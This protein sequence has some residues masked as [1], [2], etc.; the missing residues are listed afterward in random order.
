MRNILK[1]LGERKKQMRDVNKLYL[2]ILKGKI[3]YCERKLAE[4]NKAKKV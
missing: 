2:K 3:K 4:N 1:S